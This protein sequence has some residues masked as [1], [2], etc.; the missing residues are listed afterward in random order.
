M[1]TIQAVIA[2]HYGNDYGFALAIVASSVAIVIAILTA[3][4]AEVEGVAFGARRAAN[5]ISEGEV[6]HGVP[7]DQPG[8]RRG[9][10]QL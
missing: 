3:A 1:W 5:P 6:I 10:G 8:H 2:A 9:V 4:G 7:G